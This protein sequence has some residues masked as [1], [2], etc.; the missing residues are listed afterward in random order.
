VKL[1]LG[2]MLGVIAILVAIVAIIVG[3]L[4]A[5]RWGNRRNRVVLDVHASPL[6]VRASSMRPGLLKVTFRDIEVENPHFVTIRLTNVGP[7]DLASGAF[8]SGRPLVI[9]LNCTMYGLTASSHPDVT[10]TG[11]VGSEAYVELA[12]V[13]L[14]TGEEW[15]VEAVVGGGPTPELSSWLID[16]D[17]VEG[18]VYRA[19]L[20]SSLAK[21]LLASAL[22]S[23]LRL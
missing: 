18:S 5:R 7:H 3:V 4:A 9:R 19:A 17:V 6:I 10:G 15:S 16:T 21:S 22:R 20:A 8:D 2:E 13:L 11:A 14:R 23:F 1:N 12:P